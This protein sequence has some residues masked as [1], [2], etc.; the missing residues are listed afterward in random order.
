MEEG[1]NFLAGDASGGVGGVVVTS[2]LSTP[3]SIPLDSLSSDS[4]AEPTVGIKAKK[5]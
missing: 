2:L 5:Q 4:P 1:C 3:T